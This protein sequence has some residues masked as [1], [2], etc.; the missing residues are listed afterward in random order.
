MWSAIFGFALQS[1]RAMIRTPGHE[2]APMELANEVVNL[3]IR[4]LDL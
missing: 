3:A 1:N 4:L 2:P